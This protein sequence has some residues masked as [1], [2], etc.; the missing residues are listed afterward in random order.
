MPHRDN[1]DASRF[2]NSQTLLNGVC[3]VGCAP[4]PV[5]DVGFEPFT[6][7]DGDEFPDGPP[8]AT[9]GDS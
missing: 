3:A 4:D 1:D 6:V 2:C 9:D 5:V 8:E 7:D